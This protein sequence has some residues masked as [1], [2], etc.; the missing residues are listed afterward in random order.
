MDTVRRPGIH[1][2][3]T[4]ILSNNSYLPHTHTKISATGCYYINIIMQK[5]ECIS[6]SVL[7]T[8][9]LAQINKRKPSFNQQNL[10]QRQFR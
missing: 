2:C 3:K 6:I 10:V 5:N 8:S 1:T 7:F 4:M 9:N